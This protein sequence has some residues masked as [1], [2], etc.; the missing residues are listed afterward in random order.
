MIINNS[1]IA[2]RLVAKSRW[3]IS[4]H[5]IL[6]HLIE[7][8]NVLSK[9]VINLFT[10]LSLLTLSIIEKSGLQAGACGV[11]C[12]GNPINRTNL[13]IE[14]LTKCNFKNELKITI[15]LLY[16]EDLIISKLPRDSTSFYR[17]FS[18]KWMSPSYIILAASIR[19]LIEHLPFD[20]LGAC[21]A[22]FFS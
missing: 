9:C 10:N 1:V 14:A 13:S 3:N 5:K 2:I 18:Y 22:V 19:C 16:R 15:R 20:S 17:W 4:F 7:I 21:W 6:F 11:K 12:T 8:Q